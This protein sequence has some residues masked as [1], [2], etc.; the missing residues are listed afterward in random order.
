MLWKR[1]GPQYTQ[2]KETS[3]L[4]HL[5]ERFGP[6]DENK[7]QIS[8]IPELPRTWFI[9]EDGT[10]VLQIQR[11]RFLHNWRKVKD[12]DKYPS[13]E[14]VLKYFKEHLQTFREFCEEYRLGTIRSDQLELTYVNHIPLG[15]GLNNFSELNQVI[16]DFS[17]R[18]DADRFLP[19]PNIINW[20]TGFVLPENTGRLHIIVRTALRKTDNQRILYLELTARGMP[21][22][23]DEDSLWKWYA[24]AH[25]WIVA[26]FADITA[27]KMHKIW[28]RK[29]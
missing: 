20:R 22:A 16:P 29:V 7:L 8:E 26:G 19:S 9:H 25:N 3:P 6:P 24:S 23:S 4:N 21:Q 15:E 14:N 2:L 17:W 11:D 27:S 12:N 18:N 28:E 5:I 10:G 1:F 13:Y